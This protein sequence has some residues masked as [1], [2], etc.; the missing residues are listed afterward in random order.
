MRPY[1]TELASGEAS[2]GFDTPNFP[3]HIQAAIDAGPRYMGVDHP[4]GNAFYESPAEFATRIAGMVAEAVN[5]VALIL[6]LAKGYAA[7]HP[8]GSNQQYCNDAQDFLT[9]HGGGR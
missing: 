2:D 6:P 9:K 7:A 1:D 5:M 4:A 3:P 8:V